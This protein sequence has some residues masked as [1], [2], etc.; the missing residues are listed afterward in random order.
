MS[1]FDSLFGG[2]G[3]DSNNQALK[4]LQSLPLPV[5]KEYYPEVY[6]QVISVNPELEEAVTLGNSNLENITVD[7][8]LQQAQ[9]NALAK[10]QEIADEDGMDAQ[11]LADSSR[12][13]NDVNTNL[14]GQQDSIQQEM[15][16]R[17]QGNALQESLMRQQAAQNSSNREAQLSMDLNAQA[18]QRALQALMQ[19]AELGS[20]MEQNQFNQKSTVAQAQDQIN[21]FNAQN[22]Q[23]VR[24]NNTQIKNNT[25]M[26]NAEN[27]QNTANSNTDLR[28][29]AQQYNLSLPQQQFENQYKKAGGVANQYN[30]IAAQKDADRD[31]E[32]QLIGGLISAGAKAYG[33]K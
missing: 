29:K 11:F 19:S 33:G 20:N 22:L 27:T 6:K 5:L 8:R 1:L 18:Q 31:R 10:L 25:Q 23:N 21:K 32:A 3:S 2:G 30:N 7:P 24:S 12:L 16:M 4:E 15:A 17:G 14:R 13:R 9:L 28:N 26:Y